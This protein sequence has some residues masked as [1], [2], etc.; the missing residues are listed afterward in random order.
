MHVLVVQGHSVRWWRF[1]S[2]CRGRLFLLGAPRRTSRN[3]VAVLGVA[4]WWG[5]MRW[6]GGAVVE[7][8]AVV[9]GGRRGGGGGGERWWGRRGG[10]GLIALLDEVITGEFV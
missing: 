5:A 4:P 6:W 10:Q 2:F 8:G 7:G 1:T 9:G 3:A